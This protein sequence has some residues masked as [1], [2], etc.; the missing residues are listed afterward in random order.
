MRLRGLYEWLRRRRYV[1]DAAIVVLLWLFSVL[2]AAAYHPGLPPGLLEAALLIPLV[3][4]RRFPV[5]VFGV[6]SLA[7]VVQLVL[8][9]TPLT[10]N[11]GFLFALYAVA[12]YATSRRV[13]V[14]ALAVGLGG[15]VAGTLDWMYG[16]VSGREM[17]FS[18]GMLSALVAFAWTL[19]DL[20]RTRR[21][22]VTELEERARRLE[23]E[24]D[25]QAKIARAAERARIARE[26]HD[27]VAHSL[28]VV[29]AQADGGAYAAAQDPAAARGALG[30]IAHTSRQALV[31]MRRL[32]GV[33][34]SDGDAPGLLPQP[35]FDQLTELA[36]QMRHAGLPVSLKID[37]QLPDLPPGLELTTYRIVQESLTNTL[38]HAG[39]VTTAMV[40]VGTPGGAL[41]IEVSDDGRGAE[42]G[43]GRGGHGIHGMRERVEVYGGSL[44]TGTGRGGGFRV[45][46]TIPLGGTSQKA[47]EQ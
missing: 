43:T 36:D 37:E 15:A 27:V 47:S 16:A 45:V 6:M 26:M 3:W 34:R 35:R 28:S 7:C 14:A 11:V 30:T 19:G 17:L 1:V 46:A 5:P 21:A 42:A 10:A 20:L 22:Y 2:F 38:R 40:R 41:R 23:V 29:V 39:P 13:R 25:Q 9:D 32:L 4:R 31:E 12:A 24:R 8:L 33:L 44:L 18:A